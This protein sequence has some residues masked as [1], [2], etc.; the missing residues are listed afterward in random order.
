MEAAKKGV[1]PDLSE[2]GIENAA[3]EDEV[4]NRMQQNEQ[5]LRDREITIE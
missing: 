3:N 1:V 5:E 4:K 2:F